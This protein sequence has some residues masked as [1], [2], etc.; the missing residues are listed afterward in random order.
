M[1]A[2]GLEGELRFDSSKPDGTPRK[3][4]DVSR[5]QRLGWTA[6]I[7]LAEGIRDA[8]DWFRRNCATAAKSSKA[9]RLTLAI[10]Q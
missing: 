1:A 10:L 9:E 2:V 5:L 3:L 8:Y 6:R 7:N 4:L